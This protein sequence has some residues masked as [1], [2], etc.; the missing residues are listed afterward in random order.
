MSEKFNQDKLESL[1]GNMR[2]M[3]G[4]HEA[5]SVDDI[6]ARMNVARMKSSQTLRVMRGN[7]YN[8]K[9]VETLSIDDTPLLRK[10]KKDKS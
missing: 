4:G 5:P 6:N 9:G 7:T 2:Q 10:Q 8:K 1:I 3:Q